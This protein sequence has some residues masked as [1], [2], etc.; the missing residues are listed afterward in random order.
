MQQ[1]TMQVDKNITH[2]YFDDYVNSVTMWCVA[3]CAGDYS[4][5]VFEAP[6]FSFPTK[7]VIDF[8][9]ESE[10]AYFKLSPL[11]VETIQE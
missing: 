2:H 8:N 6:T 7:I 5:E 11:W 4:I 10:A 1:I 9:D 3:N